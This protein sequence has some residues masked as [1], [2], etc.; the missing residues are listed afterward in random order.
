[1]IY[2]YI[3][4]N[5]KTLSDLLYMLRVI[6]MICRVAVCGGLGIFDRTIVR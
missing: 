6:F 2:I 4:I 5:T 1:M 3:V